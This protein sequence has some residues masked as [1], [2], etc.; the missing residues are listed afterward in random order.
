MR[1]CHKFGHKIFWQLISIGFLTLSLGLMNLLNGQKS[2]LADPGIENYC[3]VRCM[4]SITSREA[5]P[6]CIF[7]ADSGSTQSILTPEEEILNMMKSR[8]ADIKAVLGKESTSYTKEQKKQ[9]KELINKIIDFEEMSKIALDKYW[10]SL[11]KDEK[12]EF[13]SAFAE[14]VK[15]SSI[16]KLDIFRAVIEYKEIKVDDDS[17][18]VHTVAFYKR[19]KTNVDYRFHRK[20]NKWFVTDFLIDE[21]S[22][23]QSYKRSFRKIIRKYG[24]KGLMERLK[25]K[26][27]E[28]MD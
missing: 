7:M 6:G 23:A 8:D 25:K 4:A 20:N 28:D 12:S 19:T 1:G 24:F 18:F 17:A 5:T 13:V 11:S 3:K 10:T 21:V 22:T 9:L 2:K 14:L 15:R 16:K 27:R 26:L